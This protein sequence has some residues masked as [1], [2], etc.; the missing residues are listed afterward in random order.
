MGHPA[1]TCLVQENHHKDKEIYPSPTDF[2]D[3]HRIKALSFGTALPFLSVP[4]R[5]IRGCLYGL[6]KAPATGMLVAV[7]QLGHLRA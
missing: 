2:T 1:K 5:E 4:I 3:A 7:D 6:L